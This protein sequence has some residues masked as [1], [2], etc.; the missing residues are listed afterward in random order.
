MEGKIHFGFKIV[1]LKCQGLES[2][3]DTSADDGFKT[4]NTQKQ[5]L[6]T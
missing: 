2:E 6:R 3:A 5:T 1:F 4:C